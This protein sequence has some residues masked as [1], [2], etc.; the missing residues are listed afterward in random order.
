MESDE[1]DVEEIGKAV[2]K[3]NIKQKTTGNENKQIQ[4]KSNYKETKVATRK[5]KTT[6]QQGN[7]S[8]TGKK[9]EGLPSTS[10]PKTA[11]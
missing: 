11:K 2:E 4:N 8:K 3:A 9:P 10:W 7:K 1:T 6:L 5:R